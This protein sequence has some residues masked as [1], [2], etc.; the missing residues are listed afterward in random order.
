MLFRSAPL[1][2]MIRELLEGGSDKKLR[3]FF[4]FR[5]NAKFL[6]EKE[7]TGLGKR[8]SNFSFETIASREPDARSNRQGHVQ[9]LLGARA[10]NAA[11]D[12]R[13]YV[14]GSPQAVPD[15]V[16]MIKRLGF[17]ADRIHFEQW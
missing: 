15:I 12:T 13:F 10:W 16:D 9:D 4:G 6:Y 14:C 7:L 5:N 2:S 8:F 11:S 3:L 1:L 17:A